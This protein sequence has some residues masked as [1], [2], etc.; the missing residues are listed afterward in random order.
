VAGASFPV[1]VETGAK[2]AFACA[3]EWPG[4]C[5]GGRDEASAL[6]AMLDYAPRY[7]RVAEDPPI[8]TARVH[9]TASS[10]GWAAARRR[11]QRAARNE[12]GQRRRGRRRPV[13]LRALITAAWRAL[14]DA[15]ERARGRTLAKGPRG[16]GR[17]RDAI[18]RHVREAEA[19]YLSALGW[20]FTPEARGERALLEETRAAVLEGLAASARGEIPAKGPRGGVRWRPRYFAMRLAWHA[21]DHA[22][23]IEDRAR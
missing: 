23:E 18:V 14:D 11:L 16:G 3:V 7:A 20:K 4:W 12:G 13:R 22:W 5:R 2:R 10:S 6:E 15:A 1:Y 21:L 19:G 8:R 9:R 17:A